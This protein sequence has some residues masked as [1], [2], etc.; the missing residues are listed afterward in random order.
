[1]VTDEEYLEDGS[2]QEEEDQDNCDGEGGSV[3]L[4]GLVKVWQ[5][6]SIAIWC[7]SFGQAIAKRGSDVSGARVGTMSRFPCDV[8]EST[9]EGNVQQHGDEGEECN[10][11]QE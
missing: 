8:D 9:H 1:M 3:E 6:V 7:G 11:T 10:A 4:A 5:P 2:D